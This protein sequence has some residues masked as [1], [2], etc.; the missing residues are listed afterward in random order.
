MSPEHKVLYYVCE[1]GDAVV[2]LLPESHGIPRVP[3]FSQDGESNQ[4]QDVVV[5]VVRNTSIPNEVDE[6]A[7]TQLIFS[8]ICSPDEVPDAVHFQSNLRTDAVNFQRNVRTEEVKDQSNNPA[9]Q[10]NIERDNAVSACD[11]EEDTEYIPHSEDSG[12]N[13]DVVELRRHARKFKKRMRDTKSWLAG[14]STAPVPID[15]I[16]NMED[17]LEGEEK[18]WGYDSSDE[19]YSYDEDSD[20]Q[21][22][23]RK[24][25]YPRYNNGIDIPHFSLTMVFRSKNQLVKALKK[26][27]IVTKKALCS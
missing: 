12:E 13:S 19:D 21:M 16:A 26:Y 22:V 7:G 5:E 14:D 27:G 4:V 2:V 1:S 8:Q 17:Q 20:G 25:R 23:R 6:V 10:V 11:F 18:Q 15:L 24:S 3:N 9:D